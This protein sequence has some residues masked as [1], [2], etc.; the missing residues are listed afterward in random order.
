MIDWFA[1]Y[2]ASIISRKLT[3]LRSALY[4]A[5][6]MTAYSVTIPTIASGANPISLN[7]AKSLYEKYGDDF[8]NHQ[9]EW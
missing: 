7:K 3:S 6:R 4:A 8:H 5:G 9:E 2:A 1:R